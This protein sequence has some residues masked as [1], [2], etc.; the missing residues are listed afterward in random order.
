MC[1]SLDIMGIR[2]TSVR[3]LSHNS[4]VSIA[5]RRCSTSTTGS[6]RVSPRPLCA[7]KM[8]WAVCLCAGWWAGESGSTSSSLA[9]TCGGGCSSPQGFAPPSASREGHGRPAG[10]RA[11]KSFLAF[12]PKYLGAALQSSC[13]LCL[14]F[15]SSRAAASGTA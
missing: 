2:D 15:L 5:G 7:R 6:I 10:N 8:P 13:L 4:T 9:G 11:R 1:T 3:R 14:F 12:A